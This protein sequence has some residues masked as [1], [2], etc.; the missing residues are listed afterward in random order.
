MNQRRNGSLMI[1]AN[2]SL[3][4][5]SSAFAPGGVSI[6]AGLALAAVLLLSATALS[7]TVQPLLCSGSTQF[8]LQ[9]KYS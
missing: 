6:V 9:I 5:L 1:F 8:T 4:A 3:L 7:V 2:A